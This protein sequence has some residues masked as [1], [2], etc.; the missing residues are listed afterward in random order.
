M[1]R[2]WVDIQVAKYTMLSEALWRRRQTISGMK[3]NFLIIHCKELMRIVESSAIYS[4]MSRRATLDE[5]YILNLY[6][7]FY[8]RIYAEA[9]LLFKTMF[10]NSELTSS[11]RRMDM[12][13]RKS[14]KWLFI[15]FETFLAHLEA[16]HLHFF[17]LMLP[18]Q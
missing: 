13:G 16:K 14:S 7:I 5:L 1:S 17:L 12:D 18:N 6:V 9:P 15:H 8:H 11:I 10:T 3:T 2:I 4:L